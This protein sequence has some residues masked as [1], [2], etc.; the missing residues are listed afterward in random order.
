[1]VSIAWGLT[2]LGVARLTGDLESA[3]IA[4]TAF[5]VAAIV[6]LVP[7]ILRI[8]VARARGHRGVSARD[9]NY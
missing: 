2:W 5:V 3:P 1:M 4:I 6:L 8:R 9:G 7:A